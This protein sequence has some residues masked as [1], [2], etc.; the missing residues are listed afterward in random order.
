MGEE[1]CLASRFGQF[2]KY[3]LGCVCGLQGGAVG[4]QYGYSWVGNFLVAV[5]CITSEEVA[6]GAGVGNDWRGVTIV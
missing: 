2:G 3:E 5:R 1:V 6:G 4:Q